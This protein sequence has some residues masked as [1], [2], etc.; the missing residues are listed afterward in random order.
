MFWK[1][2]YLGNILLKLTD[3]T[4]HSPA[5]TQ[6]GQYKYITAK[7][8]KNGKIDLSNITYVSSEIH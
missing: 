4:H 8:I 1:W 6:Q 2:C 3:G 5:N 7:N